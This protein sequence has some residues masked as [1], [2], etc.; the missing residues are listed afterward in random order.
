MIAIGMGLIGLSLLSALL[1]L[2]GSLWKNT[3]VLRLLVIAVLGPQLAN[4]LGWFSA[5]MGRQP[6]V[7]YHLLRTSDALSKAVKANQVLGSLIMFGLVY[8]LLLALFVFLLD[9]RIKEGPVE[10]AHGTTPEPQGMLQQEVSRWVKGAIIFFGV[11]FGLLTMATFVFAPHMAD[12]MRHTPWLF[13]LPALAL[14][15]IANI[16]REISRGKFG[17]AFISS[18]CSIAGLLAL[19][20]LGLYP[21]IVLSAP[22]PQYSL[23]IYNAASSQGTLRTMFTIALLGMPF[24][25]AY[26][27]AIYWVFRG[28]VDSRHLHY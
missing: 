27:I 16:P 2:R 7:V 24:V 25:I 3:V 9:Q 19:F 13:L 26:T 10:E 6:W 18:C 14:L 12:K 1:C 21:N 22:L 5:E 8:T 20:A 28:K 17:L 23:N 15:A 11:M 4:Q